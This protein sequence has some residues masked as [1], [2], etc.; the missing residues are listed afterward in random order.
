MQILPLNDAFVPAAAEVERR[1]LS[2]A[3]S[4]KQ[5]RELPETA[6]YLVALEGDA[7]C[8]IGSLYCSF[9]EAELINLAVLPDF[10]RKGAAQALLDALTARARERNC[11]SMFLEVAAGNTAAKMLYQKNGFE[12]VGRRVGFYRG[13]DALVMKRSLC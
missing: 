8:G 2:T 12:T 5:L 10:R 9:D 13:E 4:E 3:W 1:C 7:V 11:E 6:V